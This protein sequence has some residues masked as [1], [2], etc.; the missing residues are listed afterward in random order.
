MGT[1]DTNIDLERD[2]VTHTV[3]GEITAGDIRDRISSYYEGEVTG[4]VLWNFS[5]ADIGSI[6]ASDVRDLVELT[7][8]HAK[9]RLGGKTAAV[10]SSSSAY[11]MGR[12]FELS[13]EVD[14]RGIGH[15]SFRDLKAALEWLGVTTGD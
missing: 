1:I 6:S 2:I 13:K 4:L 11:G 15:A 3:S 7:N 12:M 10:F 8:E 5:N 14:D 9:R